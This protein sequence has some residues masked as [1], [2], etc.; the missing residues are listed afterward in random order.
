MQLRPPPP[1]TER[2]AG[3]VA[4]R[5]L[6]VHED[7]AFTTAVHRS[8]SEVGYLVVARTDP[9]EALIGIFRGEEYDLIVYDVNGPPAAAIQFHERIAAMSQPLAARVVFLASD[10]A[11]VTLPNA[12]IAKPVGVPELRRW[13]SEFVSLRA[14]PPRGGGQNEP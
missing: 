14:L 9:R 4:G 2:E 13:I 6:V 3:F 8:L 10:E 11:G 7:S 1:R 5:V 12:R